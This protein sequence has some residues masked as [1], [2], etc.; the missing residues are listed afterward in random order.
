M[1]RERKTPRSRAAVG[2]RNRRRGADLENEIARILT[3]FLGVTIKRKLGQA[4]DS[5]NDITAG[6]LVIEAKR[7][8]SLGP[9]QQWLAQA[10]RATTRSEGEYP[11]VIAKGDRQQAPVV[12]MALPDFLG[13]VLD[14]I[15]G[16]AAVWE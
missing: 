5:G 2:R 1:P 3:D 7:R 13:L 6:P 11:V 16:G 10:E 4:R 15:T 14:T 9:M 12:I 8:Q